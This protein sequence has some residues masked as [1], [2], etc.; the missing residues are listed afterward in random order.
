MIILHSDMQ[1]ISNWEE[2]S[3][4]AFI[5]RW[6]ICKCSLQGKG[7]SMGGG[8]KGGARW[9]DPSKGFWSC[10]FWLHAWISIHKRWEL[11]ECEMHVWQPSTPS[12]LPPP[13]TQKKLLSSIFGFSGGIFQPQNSGAIFVAPNLSI[14]RAS[15]FMQA[16]HACINT[17]MQ[18]DIYALLGSWLMQSAKTTAEM[19]YANDIRIASMCVPNTDK[20]EN[21]IFLI[22]KE[23]QNGSV[24]TSY[25][26]NGL[27]LYG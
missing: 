17:G 8:G 2:R 26:T 5:C 1:S 18:S 12:P 13:P 15:I 3:Y 19:D 14:Q 25:M 24:A 4:H 23:I 21:Q 10:P 11:D 27:L 9:K 6:I 20:K 22:C 16:V 7:F